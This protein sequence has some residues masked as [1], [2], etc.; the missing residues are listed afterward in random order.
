MQV[1][2]TCYVWILV[3]FQLGFD[4]VFL[5]FFGIFFVFGFHYMPLKHVEVW[6]SSNYYYD[7]HVFFK[8]KASIFHVEP[9]YSRSET[10]QIIK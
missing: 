10:M 8:L 4:S 6:Y 7:L 2:H 9:E 3:Y 5:A 1:S